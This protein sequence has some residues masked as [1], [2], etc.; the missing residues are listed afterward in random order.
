[1]D[2]ALLVPWFHFGLGDELV[3]STGVVLFGVIGAEIGVLFL[4]VS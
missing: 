1:M 2:V 4:G 3:Q